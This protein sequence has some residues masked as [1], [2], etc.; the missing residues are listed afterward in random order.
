M[1]ITIEKA[2]YYSATARRAL[3]DAREQKLHYRYP[4]CIIRAQESIEFAGKSI[5]QFR[6]IGYQPQ[7]YIGEEL[8]AIGKKEPDLKPDL[9]KKVARAIVIS[10]RWLR[11]SR[12][13]TRYG[14]HDLGFS[15][16]MAFYERDANYALSDAEEMIT[17]LDIVERSL[18]LRFPVKMAILN[19]YVLEDR[20]NEVQCNDFSRTSIS[21][22]EWREHFGRLKTDEK[23][24][25][26]EV[27]FISASQITNGY[28][29]VINPFGEVYPEIDTTKKVIFRII[30]DYIFTGGIFV[31]AGGF[32]LFYGWDVN[33]GKKFPLVE[34]EIYFPTKIGSHDDAVYVEEMKKLLP[35]SGSLLWKEFHAKTTGD[36]DKHSGPYPLDVTQNK[37]DINNFGVLTDF[38]E[39]KKVLEY[40]ALTEKAKDCIPLLRGN[41]PEF[42]EVYPIAAIPHG[43]GYLLTHGMDIAGESERQKTL[44]SVGRFIEWLQKRH[45]GEQIK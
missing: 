12:N 2:L 13:L 11:Q 17:L 29:V 19:G 15:P 10:D 5:L 33:K 4:E 40:R 39:N 30:E 45:L 6:G 16:K 44:T 34:G 32:P 38:G 9:K 1:I 21:S 22:A 3:R 24:V 36:T 23:N 27:E 14:F 20:D 41:M 37:E 7:H 18:K 31:C 28:T 35:F 25:K 42:G 26:Y 43:S 8:E